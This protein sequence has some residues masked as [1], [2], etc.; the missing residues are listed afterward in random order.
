[1]TPSL[2]KDTVTLELEGG[3]DHDNEGGAAP[4]GDPEVHPDVAVLAALP[5]L[6]AA[7]PA[8]Y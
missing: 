1:M 3:P 4:R 7:S 5:V 2:H 6:Q 8:R